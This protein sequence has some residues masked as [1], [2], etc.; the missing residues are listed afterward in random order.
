[1]MIPINDQ[2]LAQICAEDTAK[3]DFEEYQ[4][5]FIGIEHAASDLVKTSLLAIQLFNDT[6]AYLTN[7][8]SGKRAIPPNQ[9][10]EKAGNRYMGMI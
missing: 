2:K 5:L 7:L 8:F 6:K 4:E 3:P 1:M 10:I 9:S